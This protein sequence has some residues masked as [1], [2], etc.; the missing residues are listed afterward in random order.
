MAP[1]TR[2]MI[3]SMD[4]VLFRRAR[5]GEANLL[6]EIALRSKGHWGYEAAFLDACRAEL[7][8]SPADVVARRIVVADT[9]SGIAGF[10]SIDG[11]PPA[12]ELGNLWVVPERIGTGL[13]RRL[14][15]HAVATAAGAGYVSLRVEADPNAVGFYTAMGAR[16]VGEVPSGSVPGRTLPLLTFR[17][18]EVA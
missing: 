14:W 9:P 5:S 13:G 7:T 16:Q 12:G 10:Y 4:A 11:E 15:Q 6:G 18:A 17:L 1:A 8:F 2:G 3:G